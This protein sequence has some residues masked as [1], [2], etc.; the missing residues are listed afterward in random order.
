MRMNKFE[1]QNQS[2]QIKRCLK[3]ESSKN[4]KQVRHLNRVAAK[5]VNQLP[6]K[7][8]P[9]GKVA[10]KAVKHQQHLK[11]APQVKVAKLQQHLKKA[12]QVKVAKLQQTRKKAPQAKAA[13]RR[14]RKKVRKQRRLKLK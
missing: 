3:R 1:V 7:K 12:P 13:N 14:V 8:A 11:K 4:H 9:R 6:L 10:V 2:Q 5:A